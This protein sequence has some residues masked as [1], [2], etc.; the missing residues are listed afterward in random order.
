M[1]GELKE[2]GL[3]TLAGLQGGEVTA[4]K[5]VFGFCGQVTSREENFLSE[6]DESRGFPLFIA[7]V[8]YLWGV[9]IVVSS[10]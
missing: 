10:G 8:L 1:L 3:A 6:I 7:L 9:L 5:R 2:E 4:G